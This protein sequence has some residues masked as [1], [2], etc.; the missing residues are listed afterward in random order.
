MALTDKQ[1]LELLF[2]RVAALEDALEV[3]TGAY[4]GH[5]VNHVEKNS[6]DD[7]IKAEAEA[8]KPKKVK[9]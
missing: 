8:I 5:M 7:S 3:M 4:S 6:T 9:Q 2:L 1:K